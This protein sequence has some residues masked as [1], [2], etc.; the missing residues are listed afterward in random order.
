MNFEKGDYVVYE[1]KSSNSGR[2]YSCSVIG[3][4]EDGWVMDIA[5]HTCFTQSFRIEDVVIWEH[6]KQ[7]KSKKE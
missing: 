3:V 1:H 6:R 4:S 7:K 5:H 2:K